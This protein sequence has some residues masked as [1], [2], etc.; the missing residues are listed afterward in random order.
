M[1]GGGIKLPKGRFRYDE[2]N[3]TDVANASFQSGTGTTDFVLNAF[4]TINKDQWGL[5]M[6]VSRKFNTTNSDH[7][8]FLF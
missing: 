6:N 1:V 3:V 4:Y 7:Y 8:R 5:A 2:N